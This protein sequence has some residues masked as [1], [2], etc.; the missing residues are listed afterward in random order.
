[1]IWSRSLKFQSLLWWND[2]ADTASPRASR[3]S[4]WC[5]NPCCGGTTSPTR[6]PH[7]QRLAPRGVSI[8]VVV[9]RPRRQVAGADGDY[10]VSGFQSLL[11]WNDLA[12]PAH[13][14]GLDAVP[15]VSILVVVERPR[16]PEEDF[17]DRPAEVEVS[18]LVVVERPRRPR[19]RRSGRR[20]R[21]CFNPCC[22]GTTSPTRRP[23]GRRVH[24]RPVSILV[25]VERPRRLDGGWF[26]NQRKMVSILVVVE[27]PR[28]PAGCRLRNLVVWEFQS[29][30]WWNDLADGTDAQIR[31]RRALFQSLLWWNDLAD[32]IADAAVAQAEA[33]FQSLLWWNDLADGDPARRRLVARLVSILVVVERP[34]RPS[35]ARRRSG[36]TTLFQSL[37]WWNDLADALGHVRRCGTNITFQS[38]L[39]WND[40]ADATAG[41]TPAGTGWSFNPCCGGTTSPTG[42]HH[43]HRLHGQGCF[44]PCCGGTTSPTTTT[45]AGRR[46]GRSG[47]QSL[48]WWNDLADSTA[49]RRPGRSGRGFNPCCGGTTSPTCDVKYVEEWLNRV[50]ILVVV[51]RPRRRLSGRRL[52]PGERVS[53]L[54]VVE[55]PRRR[56]ESIAEIQ[57][58]F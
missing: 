20:R 29:L 36:R 52:A 49:R 23:R 14:R 12:D 10:W 13:P 30:L 26:M 44:N 33:E 43:G 2:L 42:R 54:V 58:E 28:R 16:R 6:R 53:I 17:A 31:R 48:L 32:A 38:L 27:R 7:H 1:M 47:F 19:R 21:R 34:R 8:L 5:F 18:I 39:W 41:S 25:V 46:P 37:L 11:W 56:Y 40:L 50:S 3:S 35:P 4:T 22:G 9:E 55:R 24:V 45:P 57:R 15:G 51:E